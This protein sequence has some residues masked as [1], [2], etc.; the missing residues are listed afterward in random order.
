[1][2]LEEAWKKALENT[3]IIRSRA[4]ALETFGATQL[5]YIFLG[6]SIVNAGDSVI[7]KGEVTVEAPSIVLPENTPNFEGFQFEEN[8][9]AGTSFLNSFFLLRGI[10]FPSFKYNNKIESLEIFEGHLEEA[11]RKHKDD[12]GKREDVT[13]GL[14]AGPEDCWQFSV[15]ILIAN[16][17]MRQAEGDFKK[18][19]ERF[20]E[21]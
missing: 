21:K 16:V 5:P 10:R 14:V 20:R 19:F 1:M 15:I 18:I 8:L 2:N 4:K 7:R 12:L 6:S 17:I 11:V 3:D 13:T 9:P